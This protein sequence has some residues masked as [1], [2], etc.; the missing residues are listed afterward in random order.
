MKRWWILV[1][2]VAA[3]AVVAL[4]YRGRVMVAG[5]KAIIVLAII[6]ALVWVALRP[7]K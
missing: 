7:R 2:L 3:V 1:G 5:G 6:A 4:G